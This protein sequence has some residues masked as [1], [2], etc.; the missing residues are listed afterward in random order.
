MHTKH[1]VDCGA[2]VLGSYI[3]LSSYICCMPQTPR[4]IWFT[5]LSGSGKSTLATVTAEALRAS[6]QPVVYLD[7]DRLRDGLNSDLGYDEAGRKENIRRTASLCQLL[8][9]D[10]LTVVA[11]FISPY[12]AQRDA[13]RAMF[14][15][16]CFV[17][18]YVECP[19]SECARRDVKG[20]YERARM[21]DIKHVTGLDAPY[22]A[23]SNPEIHLRTDVATI[24]EC[25]QH[26]LTCLN[27]NA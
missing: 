27:H 15:S 13:V 2:K 18:V 14:P 6:G 19:V 23:P 11:A 22:E 5:G 8:Y 7:G 21:G 17:E 26:I 16:G 20:L 10:G 25:T 9:E 4:I 3:V 1:L 24:D 12:R